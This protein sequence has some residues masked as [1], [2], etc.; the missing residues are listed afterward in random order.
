MDN[1][2]DVYIRGNNYRIDYGNNPVK[3]IEQSGLLSGYLTFKDLPTERVIEVNILSLVPQLIAGGY[4]LYTIHGIPPLESEMLMG[5]MEEARELHNTIGEAY[6]NITPLQ[7]KLIKYG[8]FFDALFVELHSQD[9]WVALSNMN[10]VEFKNFLKKI[11][12][13]VINSNLSEMVYYKTR[14]RSY[15]GHLDH[16]AVRGKTYYLV[17]KLR[18]ELTDQRAIS[19]LKHTHISETVPVI[20]EHYYNGRDRTWMDHYISNLTAMWLAGN[21]TKGNIFGNEIRSNLEEIEKILNDRDR[22]MDFK[23]KNKLINQQLQLIKDDF[24]G[25]LNELISKVEF[26]GDIIGKSFGIHRD[27]MSGVLVNSEDVDRTEQLIDHV[28][29]LLLTARF[30]RAEELTAIAEDLETALDD[31]IGV[32]GGSLVKNKKKT[33]KRNKKHRKQNKSKRHKGYSRR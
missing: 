33:K 9:D 21:S 28:L 20:D 13:V 6:S 1:T 2:K 30:E 5:E 25:R 29:N 31:D 3:K 12:H 14:L 18:R 16:P 15:Y 26:L 27:S 32:D 23:A 22:G 10:R 11:F 7:D 17:D 24:L 19:L 8:S 4:N